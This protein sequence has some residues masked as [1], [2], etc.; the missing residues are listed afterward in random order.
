MFALLLFIKCVLFNWFGFHHIL[1]ASLWNS[2]TSFWGYY[3][4][5]LAI[6]IGVASFAMLCNRKWVLIVLSILVDIWIIANLMY[7]RS[8]GMIID[9]FSITMLGNLRGFESS[10]PLYLRLNDIVYP[11]FTLLFV[12]LVSFTHTHTCA[13]QSCIL[14]LYAL[15]DWTRVFR[16]ILLLENSRFGKRFL[17]EVIYPRSTTIYVRS[18]INL[19]NYANINIAFDRI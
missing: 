16:T 17:L 2:P 9:S 5:K 7:I 1:V 6:S 4:P 14:C 19:S 10:L 11:I 13:N 8:Y 12:L 15:C 18:R 3:L